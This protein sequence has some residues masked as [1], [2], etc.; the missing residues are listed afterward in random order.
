MSSLDAVVAAFHPDTLR[1]AQLATELC[2]VRARQ[3]ARA[4]DL[5]HDQETEAHAFPCNPSQH[6]DPHP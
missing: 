4:A 1:E 5:A 2:E 3:R 6:D